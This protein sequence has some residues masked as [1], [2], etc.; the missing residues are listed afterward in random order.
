MI[1]WHLGT[2]AAIV[3]VTLGRR[4]V[5]YRFVLVG[6]VLPDAVDAI[7]RPLIADGSIDRTIGH[8]LVAPVVLA[9]IVIVAMRGEAR[10]AAFGLAV[11]WLL[12]LVTDGMWAAPRTFFWPAFGG[13]FDDQVHEPYSWDVVTQ[14]LE[15]ATTWL[16]ELFGA[17]SLAWFWVA[18]RMGE[19]QRLQM[20]LRDGR[21]RP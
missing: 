19:D 7:L 3:Y 5:D 9:V 20:F 4:R 1:L 10:L 12:H 21:L 18:F 6:A 8:A 17:A 14:P 11:G 15:H 13:A 16:K 2:A